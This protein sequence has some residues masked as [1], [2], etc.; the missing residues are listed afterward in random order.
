MRSIFGDG[1]MTNCIASRLKNIVL[2]EA[3]CFFKDGRIPLKITQPEFQLVSKFDTDII[4]FAGL[5]S[6]VFECT[7]KY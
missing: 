6:H 5:W 3:T 4:F 2:M 1:I 7:V